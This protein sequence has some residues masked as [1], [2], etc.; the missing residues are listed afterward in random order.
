[1]TQETINLLFQL[2]LIPIA[3]I[4]TKFIVE[5]LSA[6]KFGNTKEW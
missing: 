2:V 3:G 6:K 5:W 1:M 4:L